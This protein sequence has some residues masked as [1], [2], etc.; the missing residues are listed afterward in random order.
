MEGS[1][2]KVKSPEKK[3]NQKS[4]G[5]EA[6]RKRRKRLRDN[7][8]FQ[9]VLAEELEKASG[10][11]ECKECT[12]YLV[13]LGGVYKQNNADLTRDYSLRMLEYIHGRTQGL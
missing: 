7:P 8:D 4:D 6:V 2:I 5:K 3:K 13:E 11:G 9:A 12:G 10:G 1:T